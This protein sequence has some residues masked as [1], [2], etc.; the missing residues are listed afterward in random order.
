MATSPGTTTSPF[1]A[2]SSSPDGTAAPSPG[3]A[4]TATPSRSPA[5]KNSAYQYP[6]DNDNSSDADGNGQD[7]SGGQDGGGGVDAVNAELRR[8]LLMAGRAVVGRTEIGAESGVHLKLTLLNPNAT[9]RDVDALLGM[10]V[11]AGDAVAADGD[12][13][14]RLRG[15]M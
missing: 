3:G 7:G 4:V 15:V 9:T 1:F 14:G 12:F 8:R 5:G 13:V 10:V 11:A 2:A 6:A